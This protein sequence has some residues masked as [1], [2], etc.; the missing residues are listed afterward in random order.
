MEAREQLEQSYT[1][2]LGRHIIADLIIENPAKL[3]DLDFLIKTLY[4]AAKKGNLNVL[5]EA[6]E[7]F[8]DTGGISLILFIAESHLSIHT[9]P[10]YSFVA[11][12]IFTCGEEADPWAVYNYL[13]EKLGVKEADVKEIKRVLRLKN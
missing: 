13:T 11:I 1:L 7:V 5:S 4:E 12:D 2:E 9:W 6:H 8:K 3:S 10:E